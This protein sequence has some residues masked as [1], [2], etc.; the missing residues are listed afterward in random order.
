MISKKLNRIVNKE[1]IH[2]V[3]KII[4][5]N[6]KPHS[7]PIPDKKQYFSFSEKTVQGSQ[8]IP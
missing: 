5:D 4:E 8:C 1:N 7:L 2:P 3:N 6:I